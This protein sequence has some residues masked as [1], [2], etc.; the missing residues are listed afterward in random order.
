[1]SIGIIYLTYPPSIL[2]QAL[3]ENDWSIEFISYTQVLEDFSSLLKLE[4]LFCE[5][6]FTQNLPLQLSELIYQRSL[7]C[8]S[9]AKD[10][11]RELTEHSL[12]LGFIMHLEE[13][14]SA[15]ELALHLK[16]GQR[17]VHIEEKVN[18]SLLKRV[19]ITVNTLHL[20]L[21]TTKLIDVIFDC[22]PN[23]ITADSWALFLSTGET[24]ELELVRERNAPAIPLSINLKEATNVLVKTLLTG[25][26]LLIQDLT[27]VAKEQT[28]YQQSSYQAVMCLPLCTQTRLCGLLEIAKWQGNG[29]F[30][31][32]EW[33]LAQYLAS[34]LATALTNAYNFAQAE[35][36]CY[37]DDLTQ[38]YNVRYLQ[39]ILEAEVKRSSRYHL[40]LSVI[41]MDLDNF[42]LVNDTISHLCGSATLMEVS[43]LMIG[44]VRETD[45]VARY[46]GDEFVIV[47][48]ETPAARALTIAE[49]IRKQIETHVFQ[50]D[51]DKEI[52][53][54]ASFGVASYPE[55]ASSP[56]TLIRSAD[57][58]MYKA[59]GSHKNQVILAS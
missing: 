3:R 49:R 45:I 41:F 9:F 10:K 6:S 25:K 21:D 20:T 46:G 40:S 22:L 19:M 58:A 12:A 18:L 7:P 44:L 35:R 17:I 42:K 14:V 13:T 5:L 38:L 32:Q 24:K 15:K 57:K 34:S 33:E 30:S 55:H 16:Y 31:M 1:M 11:L 52:Y 28:H 48:P 8:F 43:N 53:L 51:G 59:K 23:L 26:P 36:L 37:T 56:A 54:T 2:A 27:N 39:K 29:Q 4:A 47:L 50:G